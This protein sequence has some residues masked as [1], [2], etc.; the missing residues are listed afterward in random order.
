MKETWKHKNKDWPYH[1]LI[2]PEKT[3]ANSN[4]FLNEHQY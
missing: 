1:S 4:D 3:M 2:S